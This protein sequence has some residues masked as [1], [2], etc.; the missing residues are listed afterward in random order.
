LVNPKFHTR[1][2]GVHG[3]T[4]YQE[5]GGTHLHSVREGHFMEW[6]HLHSPPI[7]AIHHNNDTK[8]FYV[9]LDEQVQTYHTMKSSRKNATG[10]VLV[11]HDGDNMAKWFNFLVQQLPPPPTTT[12][13]ISITTR[14]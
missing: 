10:H 13:N 4:G 7:P 14:A 5:P 9:T 11:Y 6:K 8:S 1:I 3:K 2:G 12:S